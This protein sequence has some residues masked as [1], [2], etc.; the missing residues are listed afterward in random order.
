[1][2][3]IQQR[4]ISCFSAVF[5]ELTTVEI[6]SATPD[7]TD[8]WDSLSR[9][10]LLAVVQEEFEIEFDADCMA[11]DISFEDILARVTEAV[12]NRIPS[13]LSARSHDIG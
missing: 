2:H 4:L 12:R 6:V 1:M 10:T 13:S 11:S 7:G 5:P 8:N 3:E 9:V